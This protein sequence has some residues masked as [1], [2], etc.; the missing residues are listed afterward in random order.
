MLKFIFSFFLLLSISNANE[1]VILQLKWLHQF[2]FA[3]YYTALEKGFYNDVGLDVEIRQRDLGK[4]NIDQV[5]NNEAQYGISDS[6]LLLYRAQ[7]KP[8]VIISPIFQ[9]SPSVILTLKSGGLDS[10]YKLNGK[11]L[12]FYEKDTDGF[13]ILSMLKGR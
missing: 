10:P 1:K 9:H 5:L 13:G 8:V 7:N 12:V 4:N 3:G 11:K 2:Q 6:I